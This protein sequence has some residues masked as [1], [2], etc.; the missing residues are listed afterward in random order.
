M[1]Y[2]L[3]L[4]WRSALP[5]GAGDLWQ[6]YWN[7]WW[8]KKCLLEGLNPY[9]SDYLFYPFGVD[10]VFHTHSVFNQIAAMPVNLLFGEA[11]AYNFC[12]L[13]ALSLS[14]FGGYLFV[15]E[16]TGDARAGFLAGLV[17][18]YFPQHIEQTLEHLNL[19]STQFMP[20]TLL[21]AV[22]WT[23]G[24]RQIDAV[25]LGVC[26]ALNV[27]CGWHLGLKMTLV[28][29][30]WGFWLLWTKRVEVA[31]A[32]RGL[33]IASATA[34]L[35][36][37]P[38]VLPLFAKIASG[39]DYYLKAPVPRGID[40]SYLFTPIFAHPAFGSWVAPAY[41]E[42]AYQASGFICYL[43]FA[44][45]ALAAVAIVTRRR[46]AAVWTSLFLVSLV[47][48][49]GKNPFWDGELIQS[50]T[51]P[52]AL[53]AKIPIVEN[54]RVANRFLILTSLALAA[55]TG[56]GWSA[57]A[58]KPRWLYPVVSALILF[59]YLWLPFPGR[60]VERPRLPSEIAARG[61]GV[62]DIPFHQRNRTVS[63]MFL[64][65]VHG[66]PIAGGYLS[67]YPPEVIEALAGEPVLAELAEI[68]SA[69]IDT[70]R[71]VDVGIHTVVLHK[72]RRVSYGKSAVAAVAAGDILGRKN[73]IRLGGVPDDVMDSIRSQLVQQQGG[74]AA[75]EDERFAI[76]YLD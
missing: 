30:P 71:L 56:L 42:R 57:L 44:P 66:L 32:A 7:F 35:L 73:A 60:K 6:N 51:L 52:F 24:Q 59:E 48:A 16:L 14:G 67:T 15:R 62:L 68:P 17:F 58:R 40:A 53:L 39:A 72:Y 33:A 4:N 9:H 11:A 5:A 20:L 45:L 18:A 21:Y 10:L 75:F 74:P 1:T 55:L 49:L 2:P 38:A 3:V 22:R 47:L 12:V 13:L 69:T 8:W 65:T 54:L 70:K 26:F 36:V 19:F 28:L 27:L 76:F 23:R 43:G 50:I 63:N 37:L 61:G 41:L 25:A 31:A 34:S 64:Q 29:I 46:H